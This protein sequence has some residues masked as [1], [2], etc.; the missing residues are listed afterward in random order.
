MSL[1]VQW[2]KIYAQQ[3]DKAPY[4]TQYQEYYKIQQDC[5]KCLAKLKNDQSIDLQG[6]RKLHHQWQ[7]Q[8]KKPN[9]LGEGQQAKVVQGAYTQL[10]KLELQM[11]AIDWAAMAITDTK[12][13]QQYLK[14]VKNWKTQC[15]N[16]LEKQAPQQL[17]ESQTQALANTFFANLAKATAQAPTAMST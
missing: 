13:D 2:Q 15:Q 17:L 4:K 8:F 5:Q 6:T 10:H 16:W 14:E 1:I 7:D 12:L 11:E 3:A 9:F